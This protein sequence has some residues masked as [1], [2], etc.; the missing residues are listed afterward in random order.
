MTDRM[1][2]QFE[3]AY[4]EEMALRCGEDIRQR[5]KAN[6]EWRQKNGDYRDPMVRLV[7]WAW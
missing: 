1:R 5:A 4:V 6:L 3:A 7:Y 2:E